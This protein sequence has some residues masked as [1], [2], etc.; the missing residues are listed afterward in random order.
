LHLEPEEPRN[1]V[2]HG[3]L[4]LNKPAGMTSR[5]AVD[6]VERLI[7]PAKAGHAGTLDPLATGVLVVCVGAATRLIQYVQAMPKLYTAG[8]LLGRQS[9]T[10]D[11]EG[12]VT[13]LDAPPVP[14]RAQL[15]AAAGAMIGVIR[16]RPPAFSAVKVAGRR[17]YDLA[18]K[19]REVELSPRGV[20]IYR[21]DLLAYDY[22]EVRLRIE[23]SG[24]TYIRALGR[25]LAASLGTAAVMA[26]LVRNAVGGF[27][28]AQAVDPRELTPENWSK[29]LMPMARATA[30]LPQLVLSQAEIERLHHGLTIVKPDLP[31]AGDEMAAVDD[32]GRLAAIVRQREPGVL[33]PVRCFPG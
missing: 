12:R 15:L 6:C 33:R 11:L 4:N 20:T 21:L 19:G 18:R 30:G 8:F 3:L 10:D 26:S 23:C 9:P 5:H 2:P 7:R 24:G 13:E 31:A 28:L 17:A 14:T 25:D 29:H 27:S 1:R 16:Q 22:P 32:Q